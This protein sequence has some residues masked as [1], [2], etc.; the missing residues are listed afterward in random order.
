MESNNKN[1]AFTYENGLLL[2]LGFTFGIVF[3]ERNAI[4]PLAPYIIKDLT[5]N[6]TQVG[7]LGSGLS[8]AWAFSAFLIGAWS[9]ASGLR[10]PFLLVS[11]VVFSLCSALSGIAATFMMLLLARVIMGFAEGPFLP[12]CFSIMN[13]ESSPKRRG[14]NAGL[15][16]NFFASLLG[17]TIAPLVLPWLAD[18]YNW[19]TA[20]YLSAVPGLICAV[21]IWLFVKEPKPVAQEAAAPNADKPGPLDMLKQR[22]IL[23]CS[24]ISVFMISWYLVGII[25]LPVFFTVVKGISPGVAGQIVAPMGIATMICGFIVPAISDRIG[26]KPAM[27]IF[28]FIGLVTPIAALYFAGPQW[29][30]SLLLLIGWT[31]SGSFAVFMGVIPSET[32]PKALAASSMGLVVGAGEIVGGVLSPTISGWIADQTSLVAHM[33]VM[34]VCALCGGLLSLFLR[35]TAPG[36]AQ[37]LQPGVAPQR[38]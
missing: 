12:I 30:L 37:Q 4:G 35:E 15:M 14:V 5:L 9:D 27:I 3:F 25:F 10:K 13:V 36:K 21:C 11:V 17:T 7:L 20:F 19:R 6:Q 16:Q 22:N 29:M 32:V 34:M 23:V 1:K 18:T 8:L 38:A 24:G 33:V 31:A 26:R 28:T 2:L